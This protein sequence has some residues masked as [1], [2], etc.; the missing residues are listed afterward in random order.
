QA[1]RVQLSRRVRLR[2]MVRLE[3]GDWLFELDVL[4][5][6]ATRRLERRARDTDRPCADPDPSFVE[7]LQR[8]EETLVD[9]PQPLLVADLDLFQDQLGRV[10]RVQPHLLDALAGAKAGRS[11]L[12]DER[13]QPLGL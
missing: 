12:D 13:G 6:L 4:L 3:L 1:R 7:D 5:R 8:V 11:A 2:L 10:R 9:L